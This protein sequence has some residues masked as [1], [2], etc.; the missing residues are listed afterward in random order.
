MMDD[1]S[2]YSFKVIVLGDKG[3]GKSSLLR[4]FLSN[5][6]D[7]IPSSTIGVDISTHRLNIGSK[8]VQVSLLIISIISNL[9]ILDIFRFKCHLD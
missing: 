9:G 8:I 5:E 2:D 7:L 1:E 4:R 6:F 3:V